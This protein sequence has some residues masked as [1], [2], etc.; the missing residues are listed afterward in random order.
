MWLNERV[1]AFI[2]DSQ[3][4]TCLWDVHCADYKSRNKKGDAIDFLKKKTK[5]AISK[6]NK[7]RQSQM[8]VPEGA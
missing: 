6:L 2:E 7:N 1:L 5:A 4:S 3:S 8:S